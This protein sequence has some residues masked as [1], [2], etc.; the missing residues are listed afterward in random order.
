MKQI[1]KSGSWATVE[2]LALCLGAGLAWCGCGT[3]GNLSATAGGAGHADTMYQ[4]SLMQGLTE[5]DFEGSITV[6]EFKQLGDT[7]IGTFDGL[8]GELILLDGHLFRAAGDGSVEEVAA[9]ETIPFG[10]TSTFGADRTEQVAEVAD[11]EALKAILDRGVEA[12]GGNYFYLARVDG[13]F[14]EMHVRSEY[15]QTPPYGTIAEA[16]AK[17]QTFFDFEGIRGTMVG[18]Y[19]PNYMG[20]MNGVGWHFHFISEDRTQGG[21]VLGVR[22]REAEVSW[23]KANR[24]HVVLPASA[25]FRKT[26]FSV[27]RSADVRHAETNEE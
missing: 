16:L 9:E 2:R 8:N 7:G 4:I 23:D 15:G 22:V 21:H 13:T 26:D 12:L 3:V 27:D 19:C 25:T 18:I 24:F 6:A 17:D 14:E 10:N 5:G 1:R 11:F 20:Q